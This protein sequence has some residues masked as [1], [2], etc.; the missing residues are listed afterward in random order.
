MYSSDPLLKFVYDENLKKDICKCNEGFYDDSRYEYYG[1]DSMC[2]SCSNKIYNCKKC[3]DENGEIICDECEKGFILKDSSC[4]SRNNYYCEELL[5]DEYSFDNECIKFREP[6][7][8]NKTNSFPESCLNYLNHCS[9]C[10][11]IN[12]E[13]SELKCENCIDNYFLNKNGICEHCYINTNESPFCISYTDKEEIK[14]NYPCQKCIK[15]YF[16]TKE[17]KC[18]FCKSEKYGGKYCSKCDYITINGVEK[19]GCIKCDYDS[20]AVIT[21]D[22]KCSKSEDEEVCSKLGFYFDKNNEKK[23]WM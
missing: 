7:F 16:L 6:Y 5:K 21:P 22:G 11:Y 3:H 4:Y 1:S 8:L 14:K 9:K 2:R 10:S 19:I 18:V 20:W 23:F 15:D 17:N 12:P 13:S